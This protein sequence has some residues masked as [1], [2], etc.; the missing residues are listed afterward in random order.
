MWEAWF[1]IAPC[2]GVWIVHDG[3]GHIVKQVVWV[4]AVQAELGFVALSLRQVV[5][6]EYAEANVVDEGAADGGVE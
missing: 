2:L 6:V 3:V 1:P 4:K 5:R